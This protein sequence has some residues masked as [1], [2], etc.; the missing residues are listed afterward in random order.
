MMVKT[1][2]AALKQDDLESFTRL[3]GLLHNKLYQFIYKRTQSAYLAQE[4]VQLAFIR[5]WENRHR[6]ADELSVDIQLFRIARTILI[7]ELRKET[8]KTKY[9]DW[10]EN[11]N[12]TVYED[13]TT[14]DKDS[15]QHVFAAMEKLPPVRKK[16]FKLSRI[17][18][19]SHKQIA[20]MLDISPKTVENH[21]TK[22]I[23]QLRSSLNTLFFF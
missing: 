5:L 11:N 4:V 14:A 10:A 2:I 1:D 12:D 15:L 16:V 18:G 20:G 3:Y 9:K 21:I 22:A 19:F 17:Q 7:D 6:L 13:N 8:V 23:K